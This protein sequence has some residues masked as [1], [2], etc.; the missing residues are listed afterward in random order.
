MKANINFIYPQSYRGLN[1]FWHSVGGMILRG[2]E[3][4]VVVLGGRPPC[5]H[6]LPAGKGNA[7]VRVTGCKQDHNEV[8]QRLTMRGNSLG[9]KRA[10]WSWMGR[11]KCPGGLALCCLRKT[12]STDTFLRMCSVLA[13]PALHSIRHRSAM[14]C[15]HMHFGLKLIDLVRKSNKC[16]HIQ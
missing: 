8:N 2:G 14:C 1:R 9:G 10:E 5:R 12:K 11:R 3:H 7:R 15:I 16:S 13:S 6:V 4:D